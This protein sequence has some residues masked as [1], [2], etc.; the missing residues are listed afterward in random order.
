MNQIMNQH[1]EIIG[2]MKGTIPYSKQTLSNL[3]N[4]IDEYPYFQAAHLLHTLN[5]LHLDDTHFLFDLRKTAIYVP[6]RKQLFYQIEDDFFSPERMEEL[7]GK[8][9]PL[10]SPFELV[11]T[12]LSKSEESTKS[13]NEENTKSKDEENTKS[14]NEENTKSKKVEIELSPVPT[15]YVSYLLANKTENE[16]EEAPPLQ[17]QEAIDK[18]LEKDAVSSVKIKLEHPDKQ[19]VEPVAIEPPAESIGGNGFFSET[20]AKIYIKQKKFEKALE[21]IRKLNLIYPEKSR[22]FANQI[23]FLEKLIIYTNKN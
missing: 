6:D 13:K 10:N 8:I 16:D 9:L 11:N 15:D 21:I 17:H 20:L 2:L 12:F 14:R 19:E 4:L 1:E 3:S 23:R 18:F 5:L 7:E 22:Y